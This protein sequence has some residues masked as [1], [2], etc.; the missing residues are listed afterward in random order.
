LSWL[1]VLIFTVGLISPPDEYEHGLHGVCNGAYVYSRHYAV[2]NAFSRSSVLFLVLTVVLYCI[3]M[4]NV[5]KMN[6][7]VVPQHRVA[8]QTTSGL[9]RRRSGSLQNTVPNFR[10]LRISWKHP[11]EGV[12]KTQTLS[13]RSVLT[14]EGPPGT[15]SVPA[16]EEFPGTRPVPAAKELLGARPVPGAGE[17]SGSRSVPATKELPVGRPVPSAKE[18]PVAR[19]V[20]AAKE[21]LVARPVAAAEELSGTK[22]AAV[23]EGSVQMQPPIVSQHSQI[24][25]LRKKKIKS[26][27]VLVGI[28]MALLIFLSGPLIISLVLPDLPLEYMAIASGL[29]CLNSLI[30]PIIYCWKIPEVK[31][32]LKKFLSKIF[33]CF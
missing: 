22:S 32:S 6:R 12:S 5:I 20:L 33:R 11:V 7:Q 4:R 3:T 27:L 1:V 15:S 21:L 24:A 14:V 2:F 16:A 18:L 9:Q 23:A 29:C 25:A 13:T 30:N 10:E 17:M 26:T 8:R 31:D 28:L 19:P